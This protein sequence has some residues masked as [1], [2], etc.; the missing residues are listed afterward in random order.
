[1]IYIKFLW[2]IYFFN[3]QAPAW[4]RLLR[5]FG[6]HCI[7]LEHSQGAWG[8]AGGTPQTKEEQRG[9]AQAGT[10]ATG[11]DK[12]AGVPIGGIVYDSA[13]DQGDRSARDGQLG[14]KTCGQGAAGQRQASA[15]RMV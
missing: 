4:H 14:I 7:G 2:Y 12:T 5:A 1:M 10:G 3:A 15:A 13:D 6:R 11:S 9:K 8:K